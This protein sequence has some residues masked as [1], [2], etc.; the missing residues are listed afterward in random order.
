MS[1]S[2]VDT[3]APMTAED[4]VAL[5]GPEP[6]PPSPLPERTAPEKP[7]A[8]APDKATPKAD[9]AE[10]A[11]PET[12][13]EERVVP[14]A[15]LREAREEAKQAREH[16]KRIEATFNE[17]RTRLEKPAA[18]EPSLETDPV[19][20]LKNHA[21]RTAK[22]ERAQEEQAKARDAQSE[23]EQQVSSF[24]NAVASAEAAFRKEA[25]D[26]DAAVQFAK[27]SRRADLLDLGMSETDADRVL[28]GEILFIAETAL[29]NERSPAKAIYAMAKKMGY[30]VE[31]ADQTP[32]ATTPASKASV[33]KIAQIEAGKKAS[34]AHAGADGGGAD[35]EVT[36][37]RLATLDG[38]AFDAAFSKMFGNGKKG[39]DIF[40]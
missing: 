1:T 37:A 23:R 15:A 19:A 28:I 9:P 6:T 7:A 13:K 21:E 29:R 25:A 3:L 27:E 2:I 11:A 16:A 35:G 36:L 8:A 38:A 4:A 24:R 5:G 12:I 30:K 31:A 40:G 14:L 32:G 33:A 10:P 20:F 22:L 17:L 34:S 39:A 18:P 26:Y